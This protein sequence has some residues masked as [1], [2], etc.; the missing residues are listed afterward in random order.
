MF[1]YSHCNKAFNGN[2]DQNLHE[3]RFRP[4]ETNQIG[5]SAKDMLNDQDFSSLTWEES[6]V[7][8]DM[9]ENESSESD[10][11]NESSEDYQTSWNPMISEAYEKHKDKFSALI[12][13]DF[14][15]EGYSERT[16]E[17]KA[18]STC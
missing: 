1:S 5:Y 7:K 14:L 2:Y 16:A 6:D 3:I 9:A 12:D 8:S 17:S 15:S 13:D 11:E 18:Y 10:N 4:S